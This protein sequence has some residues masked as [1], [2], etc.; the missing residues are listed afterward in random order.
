[1]ILIYKW[2][3]QEGGREV[4]LIYLPLSSAACS[5]GGELLNLDE[6]EEAGGARVV[7]KWKNLASSISHRESQYSHRTMEQLVTAHW[8]LRVPRGTPRLPL[9]RRSNLYLILCPDTGGTLRIQSTA[10]WR[11]PLRGNNVWRHGKGEEEGEEKWR[12][13]FFESVFI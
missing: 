6:R 9:H 11:I 8:W 13:L 2:Q 4:C 3:N 12:R 5:K 10:R 1:M 7:S